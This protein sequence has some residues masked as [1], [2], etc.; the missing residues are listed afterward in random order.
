MQALV[1]I[2]KGKSMEEVVLKEPAYV[3]WL[4]GQTPTGPLLAMKSEAK[5]LVQKFDKKLYTTKCWGRNCTNTATRL[6][7]YLDNIVP[8]WWC[9]ACDPYETGANGGKLQIFSAYSEALN[10]VKFFCKGNKSDYKSLVRDMAKAKGL[11][12]RV[13][14]SQA[15]AFFT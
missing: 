8:H 6:S 2:H 1:G 7:V 11:P 10:H 15:K 3:H 13:G 14:D 12:A 4:L 9:D 5:H